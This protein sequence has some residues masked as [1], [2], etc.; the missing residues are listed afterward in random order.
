M[1]NIL[2]LAPP[3]TAKELG[4]GPNM[5]KDY[6]RL[7]VL[8]EYDGWV[9]DHPND[10]KPGTHSSTA[11]EA[12]PAADLHERQRGRASPLTSRL[13]WPAAL[14]LFATGLSGLG[15]LGWRRKRKA[16]V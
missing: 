8:G 15:L 13:R 4:E 2:D 10:A 11:Y 3:T 7:A 1:E 16:A 14:P 6:A 12:Q 5:K 9:K